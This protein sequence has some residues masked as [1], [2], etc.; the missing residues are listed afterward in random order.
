M[1]RDVDNSISLL[2]ARVAGQKASLQGFD[3]GSTDPI[4][5]RMGITLK[6]SITT[7]LVKWYGLR[8][9]PIDHNPDIIICNET[10]PAIITNLAK[11]TTSIPLQNRPSIIALCSYHSRFDPAVDLADA[12]CRVSLVTKPVGPLKLAKTI[13]H[14]LDG[15]PP[16][17]SPPADS[18]LMQGDTS[19]LST[20][21]EELKLSP[22][23]GEVLDNTRMA[24]DSDNARKALESPTPNAPTERTAEYPFPSPLEKLG[25]TT[26]QTQHDQQIPDPAVIDSPATTSS[27]TLKESLSLSKEVTP[28]ITPKIKFPT[29]LV[30]DD[31]HINLSLLS[32]YLNRRKYETVHEARN[33]LEAV[34]A[35]A[36]RL[37]GYDIIFMDIT[38]PILDG[39]GATRQIRTIEERR[40]KKSITYPQTTGQDD[41]K[42]GAEKRPPALIIAFTGRS[43]IEDQT[44]AVRVGIDLF[45]T[46]PVAFKEVGKII[47]NWLANKERESLE[48]SSLPANGP[49]MS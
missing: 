28:K 34:Q 3:L 7:F 19:D 30:V 35:V 45:M 4:M 42:F 23:G 36:N 21:F 1:T 41:K 43:S 2:R 46:K 40:R 12:K 29:L 9:V 5:R 13:I 48:N 27:P 44:E 15:A 26:T 24:A 17:I 8:I 10:N 16:I 11:K 33:G 25:S 39:F 20:V 18:V 37:S 6:S 49:A 32:T 47:D 31:N 22:R 38:M 14:C